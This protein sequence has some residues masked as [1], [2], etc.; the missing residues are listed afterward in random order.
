MHGLSLGLKF[1]SFIFF[2]SNGS[3]SGTV[4]DA[5][6][7]F[8]SRGNRDDRNGDHLAKTSNGRLH[9][10]DWYIPVLRSDVE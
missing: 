10:L 9:R 4:V 8:Q 7:F 6:A 3:D 1:Q 5:L 2:L